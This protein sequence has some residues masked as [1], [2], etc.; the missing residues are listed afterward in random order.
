MKHTIRN[1]L[2]QP[3]IIESTDAAVEQHF[4]DT[5]NHTTTIME[6]I[7]SERLYD[8]FLRGRT[9]LVILD[10]GANV[11]LF[12]LHAQSSAAR[13]Y[14]IEPTPAHFDV[15]MKL[16]NQYKNVYPLSLA[17]NNEDTQIDFFINDDNPTMN[18]LANQYGNK[19]RVKARRIGS[20]LRDYDIHHVDFVKCDIEGSESV[21][22]TRETVAEVK[23]KIDEWFI[24]LHDTPT[25]R[26]RVNCERLTEIF[27]SNGYQVQSF[28]RDVLHVRSPRII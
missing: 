25:A 22:L 16:T 28:G 4:A 23:D 9:G 19:V 10:I 17:V 8:Q 7:N 12:T 18:S 27:Q 21:A 1:S 6:Q 13:I 11:G 3:V 24:E 14:S 15:L 5:R 2:D 20:I 26:W